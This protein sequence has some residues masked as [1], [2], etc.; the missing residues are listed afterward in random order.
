MKSTPIKG[1]VLIKRDDEAEQIGGLFIPFANRKKELSGTVVNGG[2]FP[3]V[4]QGDVVLFTNPE[5]SVR[6]GGSEF[7]FV[8]E[9]NILA[10]VV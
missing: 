2:S 4:Q 8:D 10:K 9:K 3:Y 1:F 6:S 7:V 5:V